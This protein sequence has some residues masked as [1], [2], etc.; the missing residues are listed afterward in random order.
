M[1]VYGEIHS[2]CF[3]CLGKFH[4]IYFE[5][6]AL[7]QSLPSQSFVE[8]SFTCHWDSWQNLSHL[9]RERPEVSIARLRDHGPASLYVFKQM[10]RRRTPLLHKVICAESLEPDT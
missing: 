6:N 10:H 7:I 1:W 8:Q 2:S 4:T 9:C 5:S 3:L